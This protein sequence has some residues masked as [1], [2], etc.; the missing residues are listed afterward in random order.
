MTY[1]MLSDLYI[2]LFFADFSLKIFKMIFMSY[3]AIGFI[4]MYGTIT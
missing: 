3:I 1:V 4:I 2:I